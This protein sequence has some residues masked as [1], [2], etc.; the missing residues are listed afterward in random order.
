MCPRRCR[1]PASGLLLLL[2][3]LLP[4]LVL[5]LL[6]LLL[7]LLVLIL[8]LLLVCSWWTRIVGSLPGIAATAAGANTH[9]THAAKQG[10]GMAAGGADQMPQTLQRTRIG[11]CA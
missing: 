2:L 4:L 6:L 1:P 8:V 3:L 11:V 9:V 5:I 7:P 10:R